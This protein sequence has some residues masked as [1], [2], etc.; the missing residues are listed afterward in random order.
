MLR[1]VLFG[2]RDA[3]VAAAVRGRTAVRAVAHVLLEVLQPVIVLARGLIRLTL[4]AHR[5]WRRTPPDRRGPALLLTGLAAV[6]VTLLPYGLTLAAAALATTA[7]WYGRR[8][9]GPA[10]GRRRRDER[11]DRHAPRDRL[12]PPGRPDPTAA[13]SPTAAP[14]PPVGP[15]DRKSVV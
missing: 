5:R 8:A 9:E 13:P 10:D 2:H 4:A 3:V 12:A 1:A 6:A 7:A 11:P 15:A 14:V